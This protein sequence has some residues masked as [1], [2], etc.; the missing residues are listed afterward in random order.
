MS[1]Q[2]ER[3]FWDSF[4]AQSWEW[5]GR[6]FTGREQPHAIPARKA[7][8]WKEPKELKQ[9]EWKFDGQPQFEITADNA[10]YRKYEQWVLWQRY[11]IGG[12]T[13]SEG[14]HKLGGESTTYIWE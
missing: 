6:E 3:G 14:Q 1:E 11:S 9:W 5:L 8:T 13:C 12:A 10:K 4:A 2:D 7:T